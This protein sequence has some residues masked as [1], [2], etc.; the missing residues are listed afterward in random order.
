MYAYIHIYICCLLLGCHK[1]ARIYTKQYTEQHNNTEN[2]VRNIENNKNTT[3]TKYTHDKSYVNLS[4]TNQKR[5]C[6]TQNTQP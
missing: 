6:P 4:K 1:V 5:I 2:T 3:D